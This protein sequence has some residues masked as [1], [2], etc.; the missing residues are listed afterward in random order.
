MADRV[1]SI[2]AARNDAPDEIFL[3]GSGSDGWQILP[4]KSDE[5]HWPNAGREPEIF[6]K[7][8]LVDVT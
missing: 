4:V 5:S 8:D 7:S 6:S 2:V 1:V 3:V